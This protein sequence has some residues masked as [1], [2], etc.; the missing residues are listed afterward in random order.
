MKD[1][2]FTRNHPNSNNW[3]CKCG[4]KMEVSGHEHVNLVDHVQKDHAKDLQRFIKD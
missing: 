1:E 2:F 4:Y 3:M